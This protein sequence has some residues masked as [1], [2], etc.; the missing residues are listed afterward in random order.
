MAREILPV[1]NP[2]D[3]LAH[4]VE[5]SG[6]AQVCFRRL[7]SRFAGHEYYGS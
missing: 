1:M 6:R 7:S 5:L 3:V 2:F 4:R